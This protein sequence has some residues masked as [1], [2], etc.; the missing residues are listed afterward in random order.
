MRLTEK[1][2]GLVERHYTM[3]PKTEVL[4]PNAADLQN[5]MVVLVAGVMY[6]HEILSKTTNDYPQHVVNSLLVWNRWCTVKNVKVTGERVSFT[7]VYEDGRE[8]PRVCG[9]GM[10]WLVKTGAVMDNPVAIAEEKRKKIFELVHSMEYY[11]A[12]GESPEIDEKAND[13][14]DKIMKILNEET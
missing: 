5:G 13:I 14:T 2:K 4:V 12:V 8:V 10:A 7:G 3:N 11:H 1:Y 6:R 9:R